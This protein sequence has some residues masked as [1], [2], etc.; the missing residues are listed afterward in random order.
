M[1]I[2][3]I[4]LLGVSIPLLLFHSCSGKGVESSEKQDEINP[5]FLSTV[6]TTKAISSNRQSELI[7]AGKVEYDPDKVISYVPLVNGIIDRS[8][9]SLGD[10]VQKGQSLLD[11][12]SSDSSLMQMEY[13]SCESELKVA[14]RE[15]KTA[16][17]MLEDKMLSEKEFLEAQARLKQAQAAFEKVK[18]DLFPY[19]NN[20]N[21]TFSIKAP[22]SGYVVE[23]KAVSGSP[24]SSDGDPLF[25]VADLSSVWIIANVYASNVQFVREGMDVDITT[26][27][28][29]DEVF[30]GKINRVSQV[31]DSEEKVLKARI[32]MLNKDLK[33]KPEMSVVVRLK[34]ETNEL[35]IAVPSDALIFD[36]NRYFV[37]IK[38]S[39]TN[40]QIREVQLQGHNGNTSY[41]R[42]GLSE[43]EEVVTSN[44]L[45]IYSGLN[46][47]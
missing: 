46:K 13:I 2:K 40:F 10:K 21:G 22:M 41:I 38:D 27:S 18:N 1:K 4:L 43:G 35:S 14:E 17:S 6:K 7:L 8:Y 39:T 16:P 32:A 42:S 45:L 29:P 12:R 28:Y 36:D 34:D 25:V 44:Q 11:I 30:S 37:V 24:V 5:A 9:F 23:K 26:L 47:K 33:L 15:M 3:K 19:G 31:F 20:D